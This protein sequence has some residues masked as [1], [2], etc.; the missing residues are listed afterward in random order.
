MPLLLLYNGRLGRR[1][2]LLQ[3]GY[4]WYYPA[5]LTVLFLIQLALYGR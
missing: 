1:S 2:R 3:W 4:Y 5:H